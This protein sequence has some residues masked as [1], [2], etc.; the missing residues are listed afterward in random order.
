MKGT[1]MTR[2]THSWMILSWA[3]ER[4]PAK[5]I[6]FAGTMSRYSARAMPQ[7]SKAAVHHGLSFIVRR[8]PYQAKVMKRFDAQSRPTVSKVGFS[9]SGRI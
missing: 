8:W 6:R 2:V 1:K 5:P 9:S 4:P 7:L 3:P